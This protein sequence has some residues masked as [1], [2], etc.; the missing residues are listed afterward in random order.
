MFEIQ[1]S[2]GTAGS[3]MWVCSQCGHPNEEN[4]SFCQ[5]CGQKNMLAPKEWKCKCGNVITGGYGFCGACG[6]K[7]E[8]SK[9]TYWTCPKCKTKNESTE[10]FCKGCNIKRG[11]KKQEE[12][13][14]LSYNVPEAP[15][16]GMQREYNQRVYGGQQSYG[17]PQAPYGRPQAPYGQP[18]APYGQPQPYYQNPNYLYPL[19]WFHY[20]IYFGIWASVLSYFIYAYRYFRVF[21]LLTEYKN[22]FDDDSGA[23]GKILFFA[24][25]LIAL[26]IWGI[27]AGVK[28]IGFKA[29]G[30]TAFMSWI[31]VQGI[32]VIITFLAAGSYILDIESVSG[33]NVLI[34]V[35]YIGA[36]TGYY[37]A[38]RM[39]FRKREELFVN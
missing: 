13:I 4:D 22:F 24:F 34:V 32:L 7:Y 36:Y 31:I 15:I 25:L 12:K 30:P 28:L 17:Q 38:N 19:K 3:S 10:E 37:L 5:N 26:G 14:N 2:R 33:S 6:S 29:D 27:V 20:L 11:A 9:I 16:S 23:S 8:D 18:Q 1:D 39:Y 35:I 21:E